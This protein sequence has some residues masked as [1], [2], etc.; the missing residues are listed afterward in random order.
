MWHE[1]VPQKLKQLHKDGYKL[2]IFTNQGGI[3]KKKLTVKDVIERVEAFIEAAVG[4]DI[5][6]L[7]L[8]AP[9]SNH[10]RK[11]ATGMWDRMV[12]DFFG[13]DESRIDMK[14]CIYVGDAAG[15]P[16]N[17]EKN[18]KKDHSCSD[19]KF[20][21]NV[22]ID[23]KTPEEFFL[24]QK[25][26]K[27]W[28]LDVLDVK[29]FFKNLKKPYQTK[30][31]I[32]TDRQELVLFTGFPA[33]GKST[34]YKKHFEPNDYV[35]VNRDLL[36]TPAKCLKAAE[37]ALSKGKSVV[38]DN[39][40][41]DCASRKEYLDIARKAKVRARCFVFDTPREVADHLNLLREKITKGES[42]H[43]PA[44]GYNVYK[45]KKEDVT[46]KEGW[47]EVKIIEFIPDFVDDEARK[48]FFEY[49]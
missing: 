2:V 29:E 46:T 13:G 37:E 41:P 12:K 18:K 34:F 31:V 19:R 14:S 16:K 45:K 21:S 42:K 48:R 28:K 6:V 40:N 5:P 23:F 27:D 10:Y 36:K 9:S 38:V 44:V 30:D 43:V 20:A 24:E 47:D 26:F 11:P 49:T 32:D 22:G 15:R 8:A 17:W 1:K 3:E 25:P 35:H 33:S 4:T 7:V 39:T